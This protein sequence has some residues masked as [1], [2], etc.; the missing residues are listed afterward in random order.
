MSLDDRQL[1]GVQ[2]EKGTFNVPYMHLIQVFKPVSRFI[3]RLGLDMIDLW[4]R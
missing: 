4:I 1:D 3:F 2:G